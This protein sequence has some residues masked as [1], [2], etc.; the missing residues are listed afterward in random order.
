MTNRLGLPS[1]QDSKLPMQGVRVQ[2][3]VRE[4][5]PTCC[6]KDPVQLNIYTLKM[7]RLDYYVYSPHPIPNH[8]PPQ[9]LH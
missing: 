1:G 6:N 5:D 7:E 3:L 2:P 8:H 9:L 4:L